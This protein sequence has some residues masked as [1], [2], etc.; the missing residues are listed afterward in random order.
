MAKYDD[1]LPMQRVLKYTLAESIDAD[2]KSLARKKEL[3][4]ELAEIT[5]TDLA[6]RTHEADV[7]AVAQTL[8]ELA[9]R[10]DL[11]EKEI[12]ELKRKIQDGSFQ[13]ETRS[14]KKRKTEMVSAGAIHAT[15]WN[16]PTCKP[17]T[18]A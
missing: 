8:T 16:C 15:P 12:S 6:R 18:P 5:R 9:E 17:R 7:A 3:R 11:A 2:I 4:E 13:P 14:Y 10:A 1:L